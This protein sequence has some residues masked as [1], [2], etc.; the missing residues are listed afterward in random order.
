MEEH[1]VKIISIEN[2]T[3][4]VKR[5]RIEKPEQYSFIPGQATEVSI[6][7]PVLGEKRLFH[8]Y[9]PANPPNLRSKSSYGVTND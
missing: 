6:N 3:H 8:I 4:D 2:I 9:V 5:F 7:T 1:I